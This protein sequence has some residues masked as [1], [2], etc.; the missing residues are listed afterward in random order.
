MF[1]LCHLLIFSGVLDNLGIEPQVEKIGKYKSA[2]DQ[3]TSRTMSEDNR[4]QLTALLDKIFTNWL[5][6]VSSARGGCIC[7]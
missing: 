7:L 3:L 1:F 5:D 6:K 2:G 4:E